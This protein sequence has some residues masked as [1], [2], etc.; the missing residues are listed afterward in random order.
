MSNE[1][2][3]APGVW[4][5]I[6]SI[7]DS[8]RYEPSYLLHCPDLICSDF[9]PS[10][11]VE[12]HWCDDEGWQAAVWCGYHDEFHTKFVTPTLIMT[13]P[14]IAA[15]QPPA[16]G[17]G[18]ETFQEWWDSLASK[19]PEPSAKTA[20]WQGFNFGEAKLAPLKAEI[21]HLRA[22]GALIVQHMNDYKKERDQ[23]KAEAETLSETTMAQESMIEQLK[24]E[25]FE[26][27]YNA[28]VDERDQLKARCDELEKTIDLNPCGGPVCDGDPDSC[29]KNEGY[30]CKCSA[31][32]SKPAGNDKE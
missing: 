23:L 21:E 10:G 20:A 22:G 14:S 28:V 3:L 27:L 6:I 9:N 8:N 17:S 31:A 2:K 1:F 13:I 16:L 32:L 30:G 29:E 19:W 7:N 26:A 24:E 5:P 4:H 25:S 15:P 18:H 12:G 11:V